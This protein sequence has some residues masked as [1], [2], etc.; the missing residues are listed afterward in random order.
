VSPE[1]QILEAC[2]SAFFPDVA[3]RDI[4]SNVINRQ[5]FG[6]AAVTAIQ[7]VDCRCSEK[8]ARLFCDTA[9]A[10]RCNYT[11]W[12]NG[13]DNDLLSEFPAHRLIRAIDVRELVAWPT[14]WINHGG[15]DLGGPMIALK[16]DPVWWK[17]S[18][19]NLPFAPFQLG[20]GYEL[21]DVDRTEAE[22][23][24]FKIP[25]RITSSVQVRIDPE[26]LRRR[27]S[28]ELARLGPSPAAPR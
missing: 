21:E 11:Y 13:M 8:K 24:G 26:D 4:I 9:S 25:A 3:G 17:I 18:A 10:F 1:D 6:G 12:F 20:S 2:V 5:V 27:L 14:F 28:N 15:R 22:S 19:F 23:L 16:L 7:R